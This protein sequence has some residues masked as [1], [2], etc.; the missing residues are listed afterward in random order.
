MSPEEYRVVQREPLLLGQQQDR[1][2]GELFGDGGETIV[3]GRRSGNLV[4]EV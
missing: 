2:S 1:G 4:L 3:G